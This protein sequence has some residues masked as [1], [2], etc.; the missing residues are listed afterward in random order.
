MK[1]YDYPAVLML[2]VLDE[3]RR[4]AS[5]SE[6]RQSLLC[7]Q[8]TSRHSD[9]SA[10]TIRTAPRGRGV[11]PPGGSGPRQQRD[12]DEFT[13][14]RSTEVACGFV[15]VDPVS[16]FPRESGDGKMKPSPSSRRPL[17]RPPQR[18]HRAERPRRGPPISSRKRLQANPGHPQAHPYDPGVVGNLPSV[19]FSTSSSENTGLLSSEC[20]D[21]SDDTSV[22]LGLGGLGRTLSTHNSYLNSLGRRTTPPHQSVTLSPPFH[23]P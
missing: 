2:F 1:E 15:Q 13:D 7:D 5:G 19:S 9:Q 17:S 6:V 12:R 14:D 20:L 3:P 10:I 18:S 11:R 4:F 22:N 21:L 16:G 23:E 8:R